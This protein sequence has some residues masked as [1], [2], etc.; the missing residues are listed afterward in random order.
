MSHKKQ[1]TISTEVPT[2]INES[3]KTEIGTGLAIKRIIGKHVS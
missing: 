2:N 3:A 1:R